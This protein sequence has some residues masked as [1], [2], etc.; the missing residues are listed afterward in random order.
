MPFPT[1][2]VVNAVASGSSSAS[3]KNGKA[4]TPLSGKQ[5]PVPN[6]LPNPRISQ[7]RPSDANGR[8]THHPRPDPPK[9]STTSSSRPPTTG[10][11]TPHSKPDIKD[12]IEAKISAVLDPTTAALQRAREGI[13][14]MEPGLP[15]SI[16]AKLIQMQLE[17]GT[18]SP[19]TKDIK[20][21]PL[22]LLLR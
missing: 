11:S 5:S 4:D 15:S 22:V 3:G 18:C 19:S 8:A 2:G 6:L 10:D 17:V 14:A 13:N 12:N 9:D 1:N 20:P 16:L 21:I 7:Q